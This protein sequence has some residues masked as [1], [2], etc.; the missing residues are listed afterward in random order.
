VN[1][2]ITYCEVCKKEREAD[3]AMTCSVPCAK[4]YE[5]RKKKY[6]T[7]LNDTYRNGGDM[8]EDRE[9]NYDL[10][11][12]LERLKTDDDMFRNALRAMSNNANQ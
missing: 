1:V 10:A 4:L 7:P 3:G 11:S 2:R 12:Q 8:Q 9:N 6:H 5:S